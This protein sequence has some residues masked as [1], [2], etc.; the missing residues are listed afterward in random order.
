MLAS[1]IIPVYKVEEKYLDECLNSIINIKNRDIEIILVDDGS[2]DNCGRICDDYAKDDNRIKVI[3]KKNEGVSIARNVGIR[4][5]SAEF[6]TFIDADDWIDS[7]RMDQILTC[8][9]ET[10][11]LLDVLIYG[12][13]I[14]YKNQEP[15]EVRPFNKS[16]LFTG[17]DDIENLQRMVFV[18]GFSSNKTFI[19]AGALCNAVDKFIRRKLILD[20]N[21]YFNSKIRI[22][23]DN[24]FFLNAYYYC[25]TIA[26]YDNCA[27]YYRMRKSSAYHFSHELGYNNIS[28]FYNEAVKILQRQQRLKE[29]YSCLLFRCYDL[30]FEQME[31]SYLNVQGVTVF[32]KS[33]AFSK[34]MRKDPF[35]K[36]IK[37]QKYSNVDEK[38]RL[39]FLKNNLSFLLMFIKSCRYE[40]TR[41]QH[42]D[43][44][45]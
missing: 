36:S 37:I 11:D 10:K 44:F 18:R 28:L 7:E 8:L 43:D 30:I 21:I 6:I 26:Y 34:E 15:I 13:Y 20:N 5:S 42:N 14:K 32:K 27:Y 40:R 41:T 24:L 19:G 38:L 16:M 1:F 31:S 12:Q 39:F 23:E 45:Y 25:N 4:E 3:H 22:G 9:S 33:H 17:A 35:K 29:L 2:P